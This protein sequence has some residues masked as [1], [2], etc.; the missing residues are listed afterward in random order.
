MLGDLQWYVRRLAAMSPWEVGYRVRRAVTLWLHRAGLGTARRTPAPDLSR[1]AP[2]LWIDAPAV[3]PGP[4]VRAADAIAAGHIDVFALRPAR[5]G[6]PPRWNRDPL[7]GTEVPLAFGPTLDYR[8]PER[9]GDIKYLWE[10]N[11]HLHLVTLA[12]AYR[13]S[14][15]D[16]H[17]A[18]LREQLDSWFNACPYMRGPNWTSALELGIRLINWAVAWQLIGGLDSQLFTGPDGAAFRDR[19]LAS[20]YRHADFI[21]RHYSRYSSANNHLIGE[22]ASLFVASV[23]WPYW[24]RLRVWG[25]WAQRTLTREALVQNAP[26]GV[27]REQA[28]AYQLFVVEFLLIAGLAADAAHRQFPSEYWRRIESMLEYMNAVMDVAGH[29]PMIGDADDGVVVRLSCEPDFCPFRSALATGAVRLGRPHFK[30]KAGQLD[31]EALF[32]LGK[33]AQAAWD[34]LPPVDPAPPR[35]AFPEGGYY[36]LGDAFDTPDEL[37]LVVDAGPLGYRSIAAHGHADALA[38]TV[39]A[40]GCELL[41]DPGTYAYH[42]KKRWRDHFR[43]TAA[44]NTV[45]IDEQD[46]SVIG[47]NFM[48]TFRAI[49]RCDTWESGADMDHFIG[50]H[51]GYLRLRDPVLHR[52]EIRL[53]KPEREFLVIDSLD[54]AGPHWVE[55]FWHFSESCAVTL[56]P[57]GRLLALSDGV[58]LE[59]RVDGP[60]LEV[61]LMCGDE[62]L[63]A[64]WISRSY[65]L[66]VPAVTAVWRTRITEP[67]R[68][69]SEVRFRISAPPQG[70]LGHQ[71]CA[72]TDSSNGTS[73]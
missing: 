1:R 9:V 54:C 14:G 62:T 25:D 22:A 10:P 70:H 21:R 3:D 50:V 59:L 13:L 32:L 66:K 71:R 46:Q 73:S 65:D 60:H 30:R 34:A 33:D 45:R 43:G 35:C 51:N 64:G 7:T 42:T 17:L 28:T 16:R 38:L 5:L 27:N 55:V 23:V 49:A 29:V 44:H 53:S 61:E 68:I 72:T 63:P 47:G 67:T 19:W 56:G 2:R 57:D 12:Q 6:R 4:Y 20:V 24:R 58:G 18:T 52:R 26:D 48:W 31:Q 15:D 39:S 36:I 8:N 11:R 41:I 40:C 69:R 37:R